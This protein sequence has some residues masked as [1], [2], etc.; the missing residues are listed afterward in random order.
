[1][2]LTALGVAVLLLAANGFFVA[3]EFA[4]LAARRSR[5]EQLAES[6]NRAATSAVRGLRELS[7]M[8]AGAQLGITM[9]SFGL[10]A[11]AEPAVAAGIEGLLGGVA[12]S[13][14]IRH[15]VAVAIALTIVVFLHMVIGEMAPKSWAISDPEGSA[16]LLAR[17]FRGFVV[18]FRPFIRALNTAANGVVRLCGVEPQDER[19]LVHNSRD[20]LLLLKESA[21][22][23]ALDAEH[24]DFLARALDLSELDA[25]A[26]MIPRGDIVAVPATAT[27]D[28]LETV[29]STTG[30][31]RRPVYDDELDRI[32]GILHVKDLLRVQ[33]TA[34]GTTTAATLARPALVTPESRLIEDLMLEMREQRQHVAI[35]IDEYGS[36]TGLV[37][38]EDLLEEIIGDFEDES[39]LR[40]RGIRARRDGSVTFPGTLRPDE[41]RSAGVVDLPDGEWET[42]AGYVIAALGRMPGTGDRVAVDDQLITVTRMDGH[43]IVE[44]NLRPG[45]VPGAGSGPRR[46]Q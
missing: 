22:V 43:R 41:L 6:G 12:V 7:L 17:P 46:G 19:A 8:L 18:V 20:L 40:S 3:S 11:I 10:G 1:M 42:V 15:T 24:H 44:L 45:N 16:L 23:G 36:V 2:S 14:T 39:D 27:I 28:E 32:R 4:L 31:S 33:D 26:A 9:A 35:V 38:L 29:A 5:L 30:R 21:D 13:P 25:E 34:R 37:A